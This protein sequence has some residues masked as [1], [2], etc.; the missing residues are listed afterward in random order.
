MDEIE[1][2]AASS[3]FQIGSGKS[4]ILGIHFD[5][6]RTEV[7]SAMHHNNCS[8]SLSLYKCI[9]TLL[10]YSMVSSFQGYFK[11]SLTYIPKDLLLLAYLSLNLQS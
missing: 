7:T 3:N 10:V 2:E 9:E 11:G 5:L 6:S 1:L 8:L 4:I